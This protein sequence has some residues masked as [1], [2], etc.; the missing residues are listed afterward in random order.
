MSPG[1]TAVPGSGLAPWVAKTLG[2]HCSSTNATDRQTDMDGPVKCSSLTLERGERVISVRLQEPLLVKKGFI[3]EREWYWAEEAWRCILI[4][5]SQIA[6]AMFT[7]GFV[8]YKICISNWKVKRMIPK[9]RFINFCTNAN[10][11]TDQTD[12]HRFSVFF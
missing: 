5:T 6:R 1:G 11:G 12:P 8:T 3:G 4:L 7:R 10:P 2:G 9:V